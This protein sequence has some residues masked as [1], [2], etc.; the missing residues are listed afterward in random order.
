[1][2][3]SNMKNILIYRLNKK[4]LKKLLLYMSAFFIPAVILLGIFAYLKVYPFGDKTYLAVDATGQY[5]SF[6]HYF[7]DIFYEGRSIFYSL[8]KS[9][10]GEMYGLFAYY[11]ASPYNLVT[12]LFD[13]ANSPFAFILIII[14]KT[15][16]C[17]VTF[18]YYLNRRKKPN[19]SNLIFSTMY[20]MCAYVIM[21][22]F[23]IMWL[24]AVILL[25]IVMAGIDDI[26][27]H[28]KFILFTVSLTLTLITNYYIGF[29]VC[30]FSIIYFA[31]KM[32]LRKIKFSKEFFKKVGIFI[33]C[34]IVSALIASI[35]LIPV[36]FEIQEGRASFTLNNFSL[37]KNF[38]L[39]DLVSKFFTNSFDIE[40][41]KNDGAPPVFCGVLA[42]LLVLLYFLNKKIP[43]KEKVLS[44]IVIAIFIVS[45]YIRG[46]NLVWSM[47]NVPAWYRFRY[48]FAFS[49][50]YIIFAKRE[51]DNLKKGT[52][53]WNFI[54]V[55]LIYQG[56]AIFISKC[57]YSFLTNDS[58]KIDVMLALT[59]VLLLIL[60]M[61]K[62]NNNT[63]LGKYYLVIITSIMFILNLAN[64][65]GNSLTTMKI[66]R[67]EGSFATQG[68]YS[69]M[70]KE[71]EKCISNLKEY[72]NYDNSI[73]RIEKEAKLNSNDPISFGYYGIDCSTSTYSNMVYKF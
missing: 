40:A 52:S 2:D 14:L 56:V 27:K 35:I 63:K 66:I 24:D 62:I 46:A 21:Y 44:L 10:G 30:I 25:P 70:E 8:S 42:N 65:S 41:I 33:L 22:G 55:I 34:G 26:I 31:Y 37:N 36:F 58:I 7:R 9:I 17:G 12:L 13:K 45:F 57:G 29:M 54:L 32:L 59:F 38:E 51:F 48:A 5:V 68:L 73:Y 53:I 72:D 28:K 20:S 43:I 16:S 39:Q 23:N 71:Y 47:G 69:F 61:L 4:D 60:S 6:L 1:M 18:L 67:E 49:F 11:L 19:F 15:S 50:M 64:L 3:K